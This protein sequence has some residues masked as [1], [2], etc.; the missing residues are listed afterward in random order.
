MPLNIKNPDADEL[1]RRLARATG[2]SITDAVIY[3]LREQLR[4]ERGRYT[5]PDLADDLLGIGR[6]CASLPDLDTR[7]E[8][9]ILGYNEHGIWS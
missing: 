2:R 6:H 8:D 3:A 4:R 1:A 7:P 5:G 9:E